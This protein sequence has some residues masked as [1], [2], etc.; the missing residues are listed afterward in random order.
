MTPATPSTCAR[1]DGA[2][3]EGFLLDHGHGNA[4]MPTS[5]V[6]DPPVKSLWTG[7]ELKHKEHIPVRAFRWERC[8][9]LEF[10]APSLS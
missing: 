4:P 7:L 6:E 9:L 3:S 5:W 1:C 2:L 10:R 8:G